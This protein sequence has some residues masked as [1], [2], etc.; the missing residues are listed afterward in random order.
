MTRSQALVLQG[1]DHEFA[2]V[3]V[4]LKL[5]QSRE[6][7]VRL[8]ATGLCHTDIAIQQGKIPVPFPV[9]VGHE[10][11][12]I[13]EQIGSD[14]K[15]VQVGDHVLLSYSYCGK[16]HTCQQR[17]PFACEQMLSRNFG[18]ARPDGSCPMLW[19]GKETHGCF[20]GQSS[21]ANPAL[22]QEASCIPVDKS[23]PLELLAPLGCGIQTGAGAIFNV[24]KPLEKNVRSLVIFGIG[25]V[26]I[27]SLMAAKYLSSKASG[28]LDV[29]IAA[30]HYLKTIAQICGGSGVDAVIDC[31]G[32]VQVINDMIVALA[33]CGTAVTVGAPPATARM[34]IEVFPFIN[35]CKTY[36]GTHAG[37]GVAKTFL[38]FLAKLHQQ[39][40]FPIDVLQKQYK[41]SDINIAVKDMREGKVVKPVL[42]WD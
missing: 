25:G 2:N 10:G 17:R 24:V 1:G 13:V 18:C 26:G 30:D 34:S 41:A 35:A 9:V 21:F 8:K 4:D 23:L 6:V 22:V 32:S 42:I 39:G 36:R 12:G 11:A 20:F 40:D 7:L 29:I 5:L 28:I 15:S 33:P 19:L 3:T 31:T 37:D 27:A 14:V 16:C 38:P